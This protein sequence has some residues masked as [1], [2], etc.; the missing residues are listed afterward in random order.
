VNKH[1][2]RVVFIFLS[3]TSATLIYVLLHGRHTGIYFPWEGNFI[4]LPLRH[5][6]VFT[7]ATLLSVGALWICLF[8]NG[9]VK[10]ALDAAGK[11]RLVRYIW[12]LEIWQKILLVVMV[13][14]VALD[15]HYIFVRS[16]SFWHS[17]SASGSIFVRE[18]IYTRQLFPPGFR[19]GN[20][21]PFMD[22]RHIMLLLSP[23]I[24]D[25]LLLLHIAALVFQLFFLVSLVILG[26][27]GFKDNSFLIFVPFIFIH[28]SGLY[29]NMF[30]TYAYYTM[31][32]IFV[33]LFLEKSVNTSF[34][35]INVRYIIA[36]CVVVLIFSIRS[37]RLLGTALVPIILS[38]V[39]VY[40]IDHHDNSLRKVYAHIKNFL[41]MCGILF[42][43]FIIGHSVNRWVSSAR[44]TWDMHSHDLELRFIVEIVVDR[45]WQLL[46]SVWAFFGVAGNFAL[47]SVEGLAGVIRLFTIFVF[48]VLFPIFL[49]KKYK[50]E[51][52][53]IKRFILLSWISFA[54]TTFLVLF[55]RLPI[56]IHIARYLL[57]NIFFKFIM[58]GY[59]LQK[60]LISK[61]SILRIVSVTALVFILFSLNYEHVRYTVV[62][63]HT[64]AHYL[65]ASMELRDS[66]RYRG[67]KWGYAT[68]WNAA[69]NTVLFDFNPEIVSIMHDTGLNYYRLVR[70][71]IIT[72]ARLYDPNSHIGETFLMLTQNE[73]EIFQNNYALQNTLGEPV[74]IFEQSGFVI[75]VY[76]YNIAY[77]FIG[78]PPRQIPSNP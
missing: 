34:R 8:R 19:I 76:D 72:P 1:V 2:K 7:I 9:T 16:I 29:S 5:W 17:D 46:F 55:T 71:P 28:P 32:T 36:A 59:Y 35:I 42:I 25:Q 15:I 21:V 20:E 58:S 51:S 49:T 3:V 70:M 57:P 37:L 63:R 73:F 24:S 66:L 13:L 50:N 74:D 48:V 43:P 26:K 40:L 75:I 61:G 54:I 18:M 56:D 45:F 60:Y 6:V 31:L 78:A 12:N 22:V 77:A 64:R 27:F 47:F 33:F 39:L 53:F 23:L 44:G 4:V 62:Y 11:F 41:I 30:A 14:F 67:L 69:N 68:Y 65:S 10:H 38:F 52:L